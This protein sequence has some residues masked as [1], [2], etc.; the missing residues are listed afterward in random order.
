MGLL[1]MRAIKPHSHWH[2]S[3]LRDNPP[4]SDKSRSLQQAAWERSTL[5]KTPSFGVG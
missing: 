5:L 4:I 2:T 1:L 3:D